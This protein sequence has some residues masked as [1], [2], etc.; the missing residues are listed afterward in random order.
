MIANRFFIVCITFLL[1]ALVACEDSSLFD[2]GEIETREHLIDDN[3]NLIEVLSIF[4]IVLVTDT[5]N[6]VVVTCGRNLHSNVNIYRESDTL[7]LENTENNKWTRNYEKIKLSVHLVNIPLINARSPIKVT[8]SDTLKTDYFHFVGWSKFSDVDVTIDVK[9]FQLWMSHDNFG[10]YNI[11]G[12]SE[13]TYINCWATA[14][15]KTDKLISQSCTVVH[16][17]I[18]DITVRVVT[19]LTVSL[20]SRGNIYY[21]GGPSS[22]L[23]ENRL[24]TGML[25]EAEDN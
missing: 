11:S 6:K 14:S 12:K 18:A 5:V 16:K 21:Y 23:I 10:S 17:G 7:F 24:S 22:I 20:E 25:I 19:N 15:V 13:N 9:S 1:F 3:F 8:S 4:D 2:A